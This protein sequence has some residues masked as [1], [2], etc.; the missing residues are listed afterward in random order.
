MLAVC[1]RRQ[2]LLLSV[3]AKPTLYASF[4]LS[5]GTCPKA[6]RIPKAAAPAVPIKTC[7]RVMSMLVS[8]SFANAPCAHRD[9][10]LTVPFSGR[11]TVPR[12]DLPRR[13]FA[14]EP[15]A[16]RRIMGR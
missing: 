6:G 10:A 8:S 15:R 2:G 1:A 3:W 7:L 12:G 9:G 13:F 11:E 4:F 14:L 5:G 16:H